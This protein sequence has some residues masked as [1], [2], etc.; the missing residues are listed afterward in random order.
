MTDEIRKNFSKWSIIYETALKEDGSLYFP[1]RLSKEFLDEARRKMGSMLF[2]NQYLNEIF[3]SEDA[4]FKKEW[5]KYWSFI[6]QHHHT[7]AFIDPA[8]ST[9]DGADYTGI[10]VASVTPEMN[11]YLR[12]ARRVRMNPTEIVHMIFDLQRQYNCQGIGIEDVAYQ[13]ALLYML[14]EEMQRR[15]VILPVK[16]INPGNKNSKEMRIM[17]MI[18]YFEWGRIFLGQSMDDFE[19]ELLQFPRSAHDDIIDA[20]ASLQQIIF[21]PTIKKENLDDVRN[22]PHHAQYESYIIKQYASRDRED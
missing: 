13:K 9:E 2:A 15:Q 5:F 10:V 4:K 11:W 8:I 1:E 20:C 12:V 7:F 22:N 17:S 3:P 16:G 14:G 18:P 19:K 21:Y 6:P